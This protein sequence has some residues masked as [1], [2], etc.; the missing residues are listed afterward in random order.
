MYAKV[1]KQILSSSIADDYLVRLV[2]EDFLILAEPDGTVDMTAESIARHTNVPLEIVRRGIEV[3][4]QPDLRSRTPDHDGRRLIL[5]NDHRDWGWTIVN[6]GA[7]SKM[8]DNVQRREY[9]RDHKRKTRKG[10]MSTICPHASTRVT[11]VSVP[12]PESETGEER[13]K[14]LR[15]R[16]SVVPVLI[17]EWI[18]ISSWDAFCEM[19]EKVRAPMTARAKQMIVTKLTELRAAGHDPG[20]VL[21][22]STMSSWKSVYELKDK[23]QQQN[24]NDG[25]SRAQQNIR[26]NQAAINAYFDQREAQSPSVGNCLEIPESESDREPAG[27]YQ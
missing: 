15:S 8:R 6:Y 21:D 24:G 11:H 18:P 4:S 20:A 26:A 17:P 14:T 3:L 10:R 12:V 5:I 1:F 19:R 2:F 27:D 9:F 22:Q 23:G 25:N 16:V 13:T 7:Y